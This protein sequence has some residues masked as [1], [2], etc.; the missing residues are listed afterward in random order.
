MDNVGCDGTEDFLVNCTHLTNHNCFFFEVAGVVCKPSCQYDGQIALYGGTS[1]TEGRIE[2]CQGGQWGT[3]CDDQ[4]DQVD[5]QVVCK[6]LGFSSE[7][8]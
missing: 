7:G 3:V 8:Q 1:N 4:F 6:T 5:A 2:V